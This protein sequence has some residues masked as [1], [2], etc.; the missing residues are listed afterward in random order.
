MSKAREEASRW[1][2]QAE[3]DLRGAEILLKERF[4]DKACFISHQVIEKSLKAYLY[5][6]GEAKVLG[7]SLLSLC[8]RTSGYDDSFKAFRKR[9]KA[10]EGYYVD[11][12][13]PNSIEDSYIPTEF[14]EEE[15]AKDAFTLAGEI[16]SFVRKKID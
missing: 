1:I 16:L 4:Y 2:R 11:T 10:I 14:F 3:D 15:D 13:Y 7:H 12:R 8:D 5:F 9:L 6:Q